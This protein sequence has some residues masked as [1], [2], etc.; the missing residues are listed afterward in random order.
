VILGLLVGA[1]LSGKSM[2]RAAELRSVATDIMRFKTMM[3]TFREKYFFL[4]GDMTNATSFWGKDNTNCPSDTGVAATEGTCNGNGD[5]VLSAGAGV[6]ATAER[7][8]FWRHLAFA[9][10]IEGTYSGLSN[11]AGSAAGRSALPGY[12]VPASKI[13]KAA[14]AIESYG[15]VA[16]G[17]AVLWQGTYNAAFIFGMASPTC[18]PPENPILKAEEAWNIDTKIDDGRPALGFVRTFFRNSY[19]SGV[20]CTTTNVESTSEYNVTDTTLSCNFAI[21]TGY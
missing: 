13:N 10:L 15:T 19:A 2:V 18:C 11:P 17:N 16:A 4:P 6:G 1:V 3:G 14:Y 9:G 20:R 5:N 12:N 21:I 7:F 8:Q